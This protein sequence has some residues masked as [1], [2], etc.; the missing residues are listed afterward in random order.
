[1]NDRD[2]A[3][4]H[5]SA[6]PSPGGALAA[7]LLGLLV[8]IAAAEVV[9]HALVTRPGPAPKDFEAAAAF[10]REGWQPGDALLVAPAW[11]DPLVRRALGGALSAAD[12]APATLAG[13]RRL[14]TVTVD[15]AEVPAATPR[16]AAPGAA[17]GTALK[18]ELA[19]SFGEVTV[20]RRGP[21]SASAPRFD[22]VAGFADAVVERRRGDQAEPC[23]VEDRKPEGG[24]LGR[25]PMKPARRV[26]CDARRAERWIGPALIEDLAYQPRRC[27]RQPAFGKHPARI[28]Y[29][30]VPLGESLVLAGGLYL[31]DE[32]K[33]K[34]API[35]W[36]VRAGDQELG[37]LV[38]KDG[39]GWTEHTL[40]LPAALRGT[41][42][43]ISVEV[44]ASDP[45]D[46][47]FCWGGVSL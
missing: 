38:H 45:K 43:P 13:R 16:D 3:P 26:V 33:R 35:T 11:I 41:T 5:A 8:V 2:R 44:T 19:R 32:R 46:R 28:T 47:N 1:M 7:A 24:G 15:G 34:G 17:P 40:A 14:W 29:S 39:D 25:G 9:G 4:D 12:L 36:I 37:R 22:F 21:L 31:R 42:S 20:S 18:T 27:V 30:A 6:R 10:V 23:T